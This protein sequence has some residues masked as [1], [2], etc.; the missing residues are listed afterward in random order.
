MPAMNPRSPRW[1][2]RQRRD[3][4]NGKHKTKDGRGC[5]ERHGRRCGGHRVNQGC[6]GLTAAGAVGSGAGVG[7][8]AG[9]V[10]AAAGA[11]LGLAAYA[12]YRVFKKDE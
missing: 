3:V 1:R 2:A 12:M 8:A 10:G 5:W 7:A 9:P 11:A 4:S 6:A